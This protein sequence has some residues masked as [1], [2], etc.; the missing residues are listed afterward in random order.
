MVDSAL[1]SSHILY[2]ILMIIK[3]KF[4]SLIVK[5]PRPLSP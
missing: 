3:L 5:Q 1:N 4:M 2:N